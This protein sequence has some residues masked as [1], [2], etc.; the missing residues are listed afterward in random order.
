MRTSLRSSCLLVA[1]IL[2][3]LGC[4]AIDAVFGGDVA[5]TEMVPGQNVG[6]G[7]LDCWLTFDF[8]RLPEGV[9]PTDVEVR[10]ESIALRR[11]ATYDWSYIASHDLRRAGERFGSG[12]TP[13]KEST[14]GSPPPLGIPLKVKFPLKGKREIENA[15]SEIWLEATVYWGGKEQDSQKRRLDHAYSRSKGRFF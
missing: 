5:I 9:D 14:P 11:P 2:P 6:S 8:R 7:Q 4:N 3:G 12:H 15:P 1:L 13:I 10:F